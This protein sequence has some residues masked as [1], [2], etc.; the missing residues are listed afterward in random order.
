[1]YDRV[2]VLIDKTENDLDALGPPPDLDNAT[3]HVLLLVN[4]FYANLKNMI[5]GTC[6]KEHKTMIRTNR[7]YYG[8]MRHKIL[9]TCPIFTVGGRA[10]S[11]TD[12]IMNQ[13][14][15]RLTLEDV[16]KSIEE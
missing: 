2:L 5:A 15:Y 9:R 14:Q 10:H 7:G 13:S 1:M 8:N 16:R 3:T 6:N 11:L 4:A 12:P